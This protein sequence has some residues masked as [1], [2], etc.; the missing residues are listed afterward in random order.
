MNKWHDPTAKAW[1]REWA[2]ENSWFLCIDPFRAWLREKGKFYGPEE[3]VDS[4]QEWEN[5]DKWHSRRDK[6]ESVTTSFNAWMDIK[7]RENPELDIAN[8]DEEIAQFEKWRPVWR[9]DNR[10]AE[11]R[12]ERDAWYSEWR[13]QKTDSEK[14]RLEDTRSRKER[15]EKRDKEPFLER[16][17]KGW[18]PPAVNWRE[19]EIALRYGRHWLKLVRR[20]KR[21]H[22]NDQ[23]E[24]NLQ[25]AGHRLTQNGVT[26]AD[27][28]QE[29]TRIPISA[30]SPTGSPRH[31]IGATNGNPAAL[32]PHENKLASMEPPKRSKTHVE[33]K[34]ESEKAVWHESFQR[35]FETPFNSRE[36]LENW[37]ENKAIHYPGL[38][39]KTIKI[40]NEQ[41]KAWEQSTPKFLGKDGKFYNDL[42]RPKPVKK[43]GE[44]HL[45][46]RERDERQTALGAKRA[47]C[48][49]PKGH[50]FESK[51]RARLT[52]AEQIDYMNKVEET[53]RS[54][55][56]DDGQ[57]YY[58]MLGECYIHGMMD[59]EAMAHQND[60]GIPQKVFEIR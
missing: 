56:G 24:C 34:E 29:T 35:L 41:H 1:T 51:Q 12:A 14:R 7:G 3:V 17:R 59:G 39:E 6:G 47:G 27:I 15:A 45:N 31:S 9:A 48:R 22:V 36:E 18:C 57:W 42:S 52:R 19:F 11:M 25:E 38:W 28:V 5:D 2:T 30:N 40:V 55:L 44:L 49:F 16:W 58:E 53:F 43:P 46:P 20:G 32:H 26:D 23:G 21:D 37:I 4:R 60:K 13:K 33:H 54:R 50:Y 10:D 8:A